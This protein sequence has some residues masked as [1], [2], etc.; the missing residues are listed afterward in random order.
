[1]SDEIPDYLAASPHDE[2]DANPESAAAIRHANTVEYRQY[3]TVW[4]VARKQC[5]RKGLD[6]CP[7][8]SYCKNGNRTRMTQALTKADWY[9]PENAPAPTN[10][11]AEAMWMLTLRACNSWVNLQTCESRRR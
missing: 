7:P 6:L 5:Q 1:M 3:G 4:A 9:N 10:D 11:D 2:I 8:T